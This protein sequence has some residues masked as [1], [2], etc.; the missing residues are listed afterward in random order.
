MS[1]GIN[2]S[3]T[4]QGVL[5]VV[6]D[7]KPYSGQTDAEHFQAAKDYIRSQV[8]QIP[9]RDNAGMLSGVEVVANG[10]QDSGS[11]YSTISV[12]R[13]TL[14]MLEE[15]TLKVSTVESEDETRG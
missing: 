2:A 15:E 14:V 4:K 5:R 3:G 12:K 1:W 7:A 6:E 8:E 11:S 13:Y 9:D 10:H